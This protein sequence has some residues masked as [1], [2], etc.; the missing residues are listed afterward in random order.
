[1]YKEGL[2][3]AYETGTSTG[4]NNLLDKLRLFLLGDGWTV[5]GWTTVGLGYRLHVQKEISTAEG[6]MYFNFR[7]A[8]T[9]RGATITEDNDQYDS[10]GDV[11]GFVINGSTG[12]NA[13]NDWD[14]QPGY[15]LNI[16]QTNKSFGNVITPMSTTAI[17]SYYFFSVGDSVHVAVEITSGLFQFISFGCLSKQ[18]TYTGGQYFT[19]SFSSWQPNLRFLSSSYPDCYFSANR[20]GDVKGAVYVDADSTQDWRIAQ[21]AAAPEII[22]PCVGPSRGSATTSQTGMV[23]HFW[24]YSPNFYNNIPAFAPLPILLER[25]D[26]NYT[27]LGEPEGIR[28][29]NMLNYSPGDLIEYGGDDWL[30]FPGDQIE[31]T[32]VNINTGFA[33]KKVV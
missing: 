13:G 5:N 8:L 12:Y 22:F 16:D 21:A 3:M 31:D 7:S 32:P 28:F 25:S 6:D 26:G 18:G 11:T 4:P 24:A 20:S 29:C 2:K 23:S 9:E 30:V 14:K 33:F 10:D 1:V 19:G 27:L 15:A 17:P